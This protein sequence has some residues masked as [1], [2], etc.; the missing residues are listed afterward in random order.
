M[1]EDAPLATRL[2]ELEIHVSHQDQII[3]DLSEIVRRQWDEIETLR[4][5]LEKQTALL[6]ELGEEAR[7][8][9]LLEQRPPHY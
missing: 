7:D 9:S 6:Q 1:A 8:P 5:G 2:T 3:E 4:R